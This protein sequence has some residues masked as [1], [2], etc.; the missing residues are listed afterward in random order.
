MFAP[1]DRCTAEYWN[2]LE[3]HWHPYQ[4]RAEFVASIHSKDPVNRQ[5]WNECS[6][7]IPKESCIHHF[8]FTC[9]KSSF[10]FLFMYEND[11]MLR[12]SC[13]PLN[14]HDR[15]RKVCDHLPIIVYAVCTSRVCLRWHRVNGSIQKCHDPRSFGGVYAAS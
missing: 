11:L 6:H 4:R 12:Y 3:H 13:I 1:E 9:V 14:F 8:F 7:A 2:R 15:R 5:A 10:Y